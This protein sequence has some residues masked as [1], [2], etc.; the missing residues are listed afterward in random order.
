V[1]RRDLLA[2]RAQ[3]FHEVN[4]HVF[5]KLVEIAREAKDS[6]LTHFGVAA[7]FEQLRWT[8]M[9]VRKTK[10]DIYKLDNSFRAHYARMLNELPEFDGFFRTRRS[11]VD[12]ERPVVVRRHARRRKGSAR[13]AAQVM[14]SL[15]F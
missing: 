13:P 15:P 9:K 6:G 14:G 5:D 7:C 11:G 4:R 3:K 10:G 12:T 1:T 8:A 2:R